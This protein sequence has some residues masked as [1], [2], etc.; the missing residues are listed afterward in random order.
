MAEMKKITIKEVPELI[1]VGFHCETDFYSAGG[2]WR[3]YF[4]SDTIEQLKTLVDFSC[5]EDID[6]CEGIGLMFNFKGMDNFDLI[7][8]DFYKPDTYIPDGLFSKYIAKG[9]TAHVQ[10]EGN[11]IGDI[12]AS[13]YL[14]ITEALENTSK[15]I[16][17]EDFYWVEVYTL[18]RYSKPLKRGEKVTI[19]YIM[20]VINK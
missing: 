16:D 10:I 14:L 4:Q 2:V 9:L 18:E 15:I 1:M 3:E 13:A 6:H 19:D 5:C 12:I 11:N 7:I 20:P 8:G 17:I